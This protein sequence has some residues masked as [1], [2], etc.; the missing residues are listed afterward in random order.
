MLA[1]GNIQVEINPPRIPYPTV[2][3]QEEATDGS[4]VFR[5]EIPDLPGC[6]SHGETR[7]EALQNLEEAMELYVETLA[8]QGRDIPPPLKAPTTL[9]TA[10]FE[11]E[12]GVKVHITL[13][14]RETAA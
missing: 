12:A 2:V 13:V 6:M 3:T 7:E 1:A 8:E 10:S 5:A 4:L 9:G 14:R 11:L